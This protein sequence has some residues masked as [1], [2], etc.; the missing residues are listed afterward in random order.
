MRWE[1]ADTIN[2]A[3]DRAKWGAVVCT[4]MNL[5]VL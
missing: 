5:P 1:D 2:L 3:E 4:A